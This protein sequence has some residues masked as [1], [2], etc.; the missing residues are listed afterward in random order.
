[1]RKYWVIG[2]LAVLGILFELGGVVSPAGEPSYAGKTVSQWLDAGYED[3]ALALQEIG[4]A[5][6]PYVLA[7]LAREDERYGSGRW[8]RRI[9]VKL[10]A[11]L[12]AVILKPAPANFDELRACSTLLEIG[13][14][15]TPCL[16]RHLQDNNPAVRNVCARAIGLLRQRGCDTRAA[17]AALLVAVHDQNPEVKASAEWALSGVNQPVANKRIPVRGANE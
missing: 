15:I 10:P 9:W 13:P 1:M 3:S 14:G 4:P 7:K 17:S 6:G 2:T 11:L 16:A 8:Y 5:A 12:H